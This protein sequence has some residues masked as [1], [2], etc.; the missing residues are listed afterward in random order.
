MKPPRTFPLGKRIRRKSESTRDSFPSEIRSDGEMFFFFL[1][2]TE[3]TYFA[4]LAPRTKK[5]VF[6][7]KIVFR[8]LYRKRRSIYVYLSTFRRFTTGLASYSTARKKREIIIP[9]ARLNSD[10]RDKRI[11]VGVRFRTAPRVS[12]GFS[13]SGAYA[14]AFRLHGPVVTHFGYVPNDGGYRPKYNYPRRPTFPSE[15]RRAIN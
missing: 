4:L 8:I 9:I 10:D 5:L 1:Y 3:E 7:T 6:D 12:R 11:D 14:N 2:R 13:V 15:R